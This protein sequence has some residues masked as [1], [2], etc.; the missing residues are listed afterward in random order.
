MSYQ[1]E[2]VFRELV[3][4][5]PSTTYAT[6]GLYNYPAKFIPQIIAYVV[7]KYT[8]PKMSIFDPFAGYGTVGVVSKVFGHD[9]ELWD[10]NPML[11]KLHEIAI[12]KID[13]DVNVAMLMQDLQNSKD[14]FMPDWENID[15]W[16]PQEF[17]PL[18]SKSWGFYH[19][20]KDDFIKKLILIPLLK[21]TR[22]FS[23]N[24][25][26]RQKLST[27][28]FA[29]QRVEKLLSNG[30]KHMFYDSIESD[31]SQ[32]LIKLKQYEELKPRNVKGIFKGNMDVMHA[33]LTNKHD[34]LITSPPYLQAQEYIRN[35][36][37]DLSWLG[38]SAQQIK[39]LGKKEI[40]Y[41]EVEEVPI[42]SK[43]YQEYRKDITESHLLKMYDRYFFGVLGALSRF[44][45]NISSRMFLF[46]GSANVRNKN[47]PIH[48]IFTE[49][50]TALGWE[51]EA[52][53]T[54]KIVSKRL[55]SYRV[56]P[57]TGKPDNRMSKEH[58]VILKKV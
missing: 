13:R 44:S 33:S 11:E 53:L 47:I 52:T 38:F 19:S 45:Q 43:T 6:F 29:R 22:T 34:I 32:L 17:L 18:L 2:V 49:H 15:Y 30:W 8:T 36:K 46:V 5:I 26:Q 40:P 31:L 51:H 4:E 48:Q 23:F 9:Y 16:F 7:E 27:S 58:L 55:F 20:T 21:A 1:Q 28:P 25:N 57:A 3:K 35:S 50:F 54:D 41:A 10:L 14:N 12:M 56:N 24:D 42:F 37:I 39:E